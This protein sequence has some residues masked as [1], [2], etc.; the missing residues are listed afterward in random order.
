MLNVKALNLFVHL[1]LNTFLI[2][3]QCNIFI[4]FIF[5]N[6]NQ[7]YFMLLYTSWL[8]IFNTLSNIVL[9]L[10]TTKNLYVLH[11]LIDVLKLLC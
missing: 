8:I 1:I 6:Q 7:M 10:S 9:K 11:I 2:I 3:Y 5:E 4:A